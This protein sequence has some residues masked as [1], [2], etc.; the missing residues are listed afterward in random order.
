[1]ELATE[2]KKV[3]FWM[4]HPGLSVKRIICQEDYLSPGG[5]N[6]VE[7]TR[8]LSMFPR[9]PTRKFDIDH[10]DLDCRLRIQQKIGAGGDIVSFK[11][12]C[13]NAGGRDG[14]SNKGKCPMQNSNSIAADPRNFLS[15][16]IYSIDLIH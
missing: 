14:G 9:I 1:L 11:I 16:I 8:N 15:L 2:M 5:S 13:L 6:K 4:H 7:R 12:C 10:L 3:D